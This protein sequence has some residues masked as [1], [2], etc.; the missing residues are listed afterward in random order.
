MKIQTQPHGNL[1][2]LVAHGPLVAD[3]LDDLRRAVETALA[4]GNKRVVIDLADVPYL[5]SAGIE[6][7]L[8]LCGVHLATPQ[9]PKLASLSETCLE[10]LELTDVL[11]RI[12]VFDTVDNAL[13]SCQ[14]G[15]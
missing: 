10:A 6:L 2:V 8:N 13:R 14:R 9:R 7:L 4:A 15:T 12:D 3:E 1:T 11:P 5:D